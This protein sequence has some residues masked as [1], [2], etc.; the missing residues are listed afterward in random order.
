MNF[1]PHETVERLRKQYPSGTRVELIRMDDPY[2]RKLKPG[3]LGTV[4]MVDSA[5]TIHVSWDC[6]SSLGVAFGED[7]VRIVGER[8][9]D[10]G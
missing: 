6:G 2:N 5:G 4:Q 10:N 8:G 9:G 1:P 3:C 7:E